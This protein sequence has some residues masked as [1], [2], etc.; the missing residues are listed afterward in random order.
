MPVGC[1]SIFPL[2]LIWLVAFFFFFFFCLLN[3][4]GGVS[5]DHDDEKALV[6]FLN[7][8]KGDFV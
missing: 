3:L 4:A 1:S 2:L 7:E 8:S 5:A 6:G